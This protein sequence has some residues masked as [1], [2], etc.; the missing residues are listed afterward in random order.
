MKENIVIFWCYNN[1]NKLQYLSTP[2]TLKMEY[3]RY[4]T[5]HKD[6]KHNDIQSNDIQHNETKYNDTQDNKIE[7]A[8]QRTDA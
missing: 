8:T 6:I 1:T 7:N 2:G 4:D 5:E 3:W